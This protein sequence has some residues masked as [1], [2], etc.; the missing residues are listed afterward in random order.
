MY[1]VF[2]FYVEE[3]K[4]MAYTVDELERNILDDDSDVGDDLNDSAY[5]RRIRESKNSSVLRICLMSHW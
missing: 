5:Y 3:D 4:A 1:G 2:D